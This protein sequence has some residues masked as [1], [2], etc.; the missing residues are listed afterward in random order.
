MIT[1]LLVLLAFV[2]QSAPGST[3]ALLARYVQSL[4][5]E[6]AL[7]AVRTRVTTGRFDN[8]RGVSTTF[9][10]V[11]K[12]PAMK[13]TIIGPAAVE[14]DEGSA[15]AYDGA[16]GWDKNVTG[17]G[18]RD[19]TGPDLASL[20]READ[21]LAPLHLLEGCATPAA[22][23]AGANDVIT[24]LLADGRPM[25]YAFSRATGLLNGYETELP[26]R[27]GTF[28]IAYE[29]YRA[30]DG[31]MIPHKLTIR[32]AGQTITYAADSIRQNVTVDDAVFRKPAR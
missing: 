26:S 24:C 10:T 20:A 14:A 8:G 21:M 6:A 31:L 13:V 25:T 18:L 28:N 19:L 5:G 12:A 4:G 17:T 11:E 16:N 7:R 9:R 27:K 29:D 30:V 23:T 3:E 22:R 2:T 32:V 15:R 1:S